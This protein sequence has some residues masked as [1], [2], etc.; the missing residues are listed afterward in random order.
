MWRFLHFRG[1]ED[2]ELW[3]EWGQTG[4]TPFNL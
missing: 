3:G 4:L 2:L 1:H